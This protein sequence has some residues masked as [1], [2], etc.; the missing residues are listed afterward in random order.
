LNHNHCLSTIFLPKKV[1]HLSTRLTH[2]ELN[3]DTVVQKVYKYKKGLN[4][5]L[6]MGT[7]FYINSSNL[8]SPSPDHDHDIPMSFRMV[9]EKLLDQVFFPHGF[10]IALST[11]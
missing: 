4:D 7:P 5:F 9:L 1:Q 11:C 3:H 2:C 8:P 6:G 10:G